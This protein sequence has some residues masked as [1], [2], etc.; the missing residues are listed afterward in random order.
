M[1]SIIET[2]RSKLIAAFEK[3]EAEAA[4]STAGVEDPAALAAA[5]ADYL[6]E[7]LSA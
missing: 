5:R 3:W 7:L 6:I 4:A 1:E 2:T